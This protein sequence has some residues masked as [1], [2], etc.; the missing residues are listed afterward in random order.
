MTTQEEKYIHFVSSIVNL[1]NARHILLEINRIRDCSLVG[2]AFQFA[3]VEYSKPYKNS[4]GVASKGAMYKL[5]DSYIPSIHHEL[6]KRIL[7]ARDQIHAHS[8]LTVKEAKLT[9]TNSS[10]GKDTTLVQNNIN[11]R[12]EFSNL[13]EIISLIEQT[14]ESMYLE[15][16]R[17]E[18]ALPIN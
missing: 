18:A 2:P 13:D 12:E 4:R 16:K 7:T 17:M 11:N 1:N 9:V 3:L 10:D 8:D 15:V 5:E 6:H 14:L